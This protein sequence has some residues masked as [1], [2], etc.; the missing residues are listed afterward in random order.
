MPINQLTA[1]G[2]GMLSGVASSYF[3]GLLDEYTNAAAAYSVRRLSST[4][5]GALIRVREDSGDTEADIG[6]DANGDLDTA[7]LL[8]HCGANSGFVTIW[9]DQSGNSRNFTQASA[10]A[11]PQIVNT[12]SL[13]TD[14]SK[15]C[16]SSNG[17]K[18]FTT[19]YNI[20][21][22]LNS[23]IGVFRFSGTNSRLWTTDGSNSGIRNTAGNT[24]NIR[25]TIDVV[26]S[27][28]TTT[29]GQILVST[30]GTTS[31]STFL[32]GSSGGSGNIGSYVT[33]VLEYG[34]SANTD[35]VGK[36]Q[37]LIYYNTTQLSNRLGIESNIN[38][39]F[40]IYSPPSGIGTWAIGTTFV[41][42]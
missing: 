28:N 4:Y 25:G 35:H 31:C 36:V 23:T 29:L 37:E 21:S 24:L 34:A 8:A 38:S 12:G 10:G 9:Y 30:F 6:F 16:L 20:S 26:I 27:S 17:S 32:N 41:I 1:E 39:Y 7:T 13:I 42:Q 5:E 3:T 2:F 19:S 18:T 22:S 40:S 15:V 14:N 33:G 11:Q